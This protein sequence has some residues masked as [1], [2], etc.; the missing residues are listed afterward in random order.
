[1]MEP[2]DTI[3]IAP[4]VLITIAR[5]ATLQVD[6]VDSMGQIPVDVGRWVSGSPVGPGIAL[7]IVE[8]TV[9]V[10]LYVVTRPGY[11]MLD[12]SREVQTAVKRSITDLV[13]MEVKVVNVH[14]E[15]VAGDDDKSAVAR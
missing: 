2:Q 9:R 12:I 5:H 11:S 7:S 1:M 4:T 10:D 6:G 8:N 15:D 13:G 3:T 14:I